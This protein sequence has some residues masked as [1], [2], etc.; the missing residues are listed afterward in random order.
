MGSTR[1]L[2]GGNSKGLSH[3]MSVLPELDL[4]APLL[5]ETSFSGTV[6][7]LSSQ[8]PKQTSELQCD[9]GFKEPGNAGPTSQPGLEGGS[10]PRWAFQ[11]LSCP[12]SWD[13]LSVPIHFPQRLLIYKMFLGV[14]KKLEIA[15]LI[16]VHNASCVGPC[17]LFQDSQ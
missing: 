15:G 8:H 16:L 4:P 9:P 7:L 6:F 2:E 3:P 17:L 10:P 11:A 12:N 14:V 1:D 5:H 13:F